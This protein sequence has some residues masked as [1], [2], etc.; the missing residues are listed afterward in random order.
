MMMGVDEARHDDRVAG[1]DDFGVVGF[2]VGAD[3]NDAVALHEDVAGLQVR[4]IG[5]HR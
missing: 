5:I 1:V 3:A 4:D 2:D